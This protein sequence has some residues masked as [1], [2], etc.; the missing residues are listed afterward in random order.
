MAK[1]FLAIIVAVLGIARPVQV[2]AQAKLQ[3]GFDAEEYADMLQLNFVAM[4]DTLGDK[5]VY[6]MKKGRYQKQ[7][8]S[9]E[10]GLYNRCEILVRNGNTAIVSLRGTVG[11]TESW[12]ENFYAAMVSASGDLKINDSTTFHYQLSENAAA[13]VHVGWLLG[14]AHLAPLIDAELAPLLSQG[15]TDVIVMGHSQG[16][17]LA[18][19]TTSYLWYK[20][21]QRY[22]ALQLKT[23]AS[24][25][26]KPG[27]LYYAYDFDFITRGG[28]GFRVI[29]TADWVPETPLSVQTKNDFNT[30]NPIT[31]AK[32]VLKKQK[33]FVRLVLNHIYNKMTKASNIT[34]KR[35]KKYL[36][37][38]I[39]KQVQK[40][41]PEYVQPSYAANSNYMTAGA[42]VILVA[43]SAYN[44]QFPFDGKNVFVHHMLKPY[45]YLL[46]KYYPTK[47]N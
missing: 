27:N 46:E 6:Q 20:Y 42:P 45:L 41:L 47:D 43:D 25:A 5:A 40:N 37:A 28:F 31:D 30:V 14:L 17:A 3:S 39:Y 7:F 29:N 24:A 23:Y 8:R 13:T 19:L 16:G 36:G 9:A 2:Y 11:K 44:S 18:F 21:H 22:P 4:A 38:T 12:L 1:Y 32:N 33:F 10:V 34:T 35:Y 15:I 26:P